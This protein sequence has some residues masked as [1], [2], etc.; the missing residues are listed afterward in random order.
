M[1][2]SSVRAVAT[3]YTTAQIDSAIEALTEREE[4]IL[5]IAGEDEGERL[6]HLLLGRRVR[7]RM[8]A[9]EDLKQAFRAEMG[10]VRQTLSND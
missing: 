3:T 6:T 10:A 1:K 7:A 8:E 4:E 9:G 5:E 2:A